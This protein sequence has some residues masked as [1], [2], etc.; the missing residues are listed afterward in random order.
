MGGHDGTAGVV[1][2]TREGMSS[3]Y[4]LSIGCVE[5]NLCAAFQGGHFAALERPE[6]LLADLEEFIGQVWVAP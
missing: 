6:A 4:Q 2:P 3:Y 5:L 1:P